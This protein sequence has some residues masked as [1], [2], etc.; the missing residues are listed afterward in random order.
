M[1]LKL[2]YLWMPSGLFSVPKKII[3]SYESINKIP[4]MGDVIYGEIIQIKQH[5][6]LENKSGRIHNVHEGMKSLFVFGN[7]YAEDYYE[8]FVPE[9]FISKVDLLA[10][11][12]IVGIVKHK[13]DSVIDPTR[14]KILGYV[15][16][17]DNKVINTR[18]FN[19]IQPKNKELTSFNKRSKLILVVGTTMN[20]GKSTTATAC[21]WALTKM[22]YNVRA[23]KITGTASLKDILSMEDAGAEMA[24]DFTYLGYPSTYM[25]NEQELLNI[26]TSIDLKYCN[27][28]KN[29][30]VVE[31]AD[32][33]LQRETKMLL[34]SDYIKRRIYKLIFASHDALGAI[35]GIKILK[36]E[37]DL[38]PNAISGLCSSS[39]L[40][41]REL[42]EICD[43]PVFNNLLP[44]L[45]VMSKL[46]F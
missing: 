24:I 29:F 1:K 45:D 26:V 22:G 4:E 44:D 18:N 31:I 10:R 14:I 34:E 5:K 3:K 39:P 7:R 40:A 23:S 17:K 8:G 9:E 6:S 2:D 43:I 19:L 42:S 27:N 35:G 32:G 41:V 28:R 30:W 21:C 20:S 12:G 46:F 37:F 13:N 11:S 33:I 25:L 15:V 38:I 36:D 16:D